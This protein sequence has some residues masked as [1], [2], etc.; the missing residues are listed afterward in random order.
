MSLQ[1]KEATLITR[2][3]DGRVISERGIDIELVQRGDLIK[4]I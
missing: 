1:A 2:D 3:T 4:V